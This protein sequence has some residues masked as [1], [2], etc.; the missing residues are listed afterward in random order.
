LGIHLF[1]SATR[2]GL[3]LLLFAVLV[4]WGYMGLAARVQQNPIREAA[5]LAKTIQKPVVIWRQRTPSF[6]VYYGAV[7]KT[8]QPKIGEL[9]LTKSKHLIDI[10]GYRV[11]Y[12]KRGIVLAEKI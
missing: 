11:L 9:F 3:A 6:S 5:L 7:V 10:Q 2:Y 8:A 1:G 4:N 12:E